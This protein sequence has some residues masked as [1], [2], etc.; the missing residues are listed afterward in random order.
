MSSDF[1]GD[2][3][4]DKVFADPQATVAGME[5]AGQLHVLLGDGKG[6]VQVH[7]SMPNVSDGAEPGDQFGFSFA[8]YDA[9]QD[10]CSDLAV[11]IPYEDVGTAADA[12]LVHLIFGSTLGIGQGTPDKGF[13]HGAA[14]GETS[15]AEDWVGY[16]VATTQSA[17]GIPYLIIGAPG[18]DVSGKTDSGLVSAVY[19]TAYTAVSFDQDSPGVWEDREAY[20]QFGSAIVASGDYFVVGVPGESVDTDLSAGVVMAFR[21][22][23]NTDGI[24]APSFGMGQLRAAGSEK[25]AETGDRYGTSMAFLPYRLSPTDFKNQFLLAVG[26]PGEDLADV[27]DAGAV[28]TYRISGTGEV[29]ELNW[30]DQNTA[31]VEGEA[32]PGDFFGQAL[33]ALD[34]GGS[35]STETNT[36]LAVGVPGEES[37]EEH[38]DKGGVHILP[39]LGA[40][41]ASD[42]WIEPGAGIPSPPAS[43][44]LVGTSLGTSG[45]VLLVGM[46]Y[47]PAGEHAVHGFPGGRTSDAAQI[48]TWKPGQ[49]GIPAGDGAFGAVVR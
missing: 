33:T 26:V 16:A 24:P 41:G 11:G 42:R 12:G 40:P 10:G 37:T 35:V 29:T 9:N 14:L 45:T 27:M 49:G 22:S 4:R 20:D 15:E 38:L 39:F 17:T 46:P 3:V 44:Q 8:V 18:E 19:G 31:D 36:R 48:S 47:G 28:Q 2:G 6:T 25:S 43:R 32:E 13:R 5:K 7:Q 34:I 30:I 1:N 21:A 23:I